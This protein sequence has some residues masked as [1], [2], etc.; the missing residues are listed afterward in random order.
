MNAV[1]DASPGSPRRQH[2]LQC[3]AHAVESRLTA[4][5]IP[6]PA[7][8]RHLY[9]TLSA[10]PPSP[11]MSA[12]CADLETALAICGSADQ[13]VRLTSRVRSI[14]T[15]L[16]CRSPEAGLG[17]GTTPEKKH[18]SGLYGIAALPAHLRTYLPFRRTSE[19]FHCT[20][21]QRFSSSTRVA[22]CSSSFYQI[23]KSVK[24]SKTEFET[25]KIK[26]TTF[27]FRSYLFLVLALPEDTCT[28]RKSTSYMSSATR[29]FGFDLSIRF[30][31]VLTS[32]CRPAP[33]TAFCFGVSVLSSSVPLVLENVLY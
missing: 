7:R 22:I 29:L 18:K 19:T 11:M 20:S 14:D 15:D 16:R 26:I 12:R 1:A 24:R 10:R 21:I 27:L 6:P 8:H 31:T 30:S 28:I 13:H 23:A 17:G 33:A 3:G 25:K 9:P 4:M 32:Q 2:L 5:S